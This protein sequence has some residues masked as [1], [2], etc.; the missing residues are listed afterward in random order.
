MKSFA[1][2]HHHG[3]IVTDIAASIVALERDLGMTF[4][5]VRKFDPIRVWLP[6]DGWG[7]AHIA[8]TYSRAGPIHTELIEMLAPGPYEVLR[9]VSTDHVGA[10]VANVGDEVKAL[11][12]DGWTLVMAGASPKHHYGQMA[13]LSKDEGPVL[14]LVGEPIRPMIEEWIAAAG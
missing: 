10:W 1:S 6:D 13:Y 12:A 9:A 7:E 3:R 14:E 11:L 2:L 5:P 8:V 4:A